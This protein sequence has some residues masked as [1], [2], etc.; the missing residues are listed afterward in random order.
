[1]HVNTNRLTWIASD[2]VS[3]VDELTSWATALPC[4]LSLQKVSMLSTMDI[5]NRQAIDS[6]MGTAVRRLQVLPACLPSG[7]QFTGH[8][9]VAR[10]AQVHQVLWGL[11]RAASHFI[12]MLCRLAAIIVHSLFVQ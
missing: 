3:Q 4:R 2:V 8:R 1:M 12:E 5:S 6:S 9:D 7:A 10:Q 11:G